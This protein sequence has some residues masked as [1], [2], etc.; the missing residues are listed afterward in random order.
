MN[1]LIRFFLENHKLTIILSIM[2]VAFGVMG[3]ANLNAESFPS[4]NFAMVTVETRY[5]GATAEDIRTKITKPIEDKIREVSGLKDVRSVSKS[6]L[7]SIFVRVDMDNEDEKE[8]LEELQ[9]AVDSVNDLPADLRDDPVYTELN[10]EEFPAVEIAIMGPNDNRERDVMTDLLKEELEDSK[11]V[12]DA[13]LVGWQKRQF[14]IR[15]D[16]KK[17]EAF[18]IGL[19]EVLRKIRQ[20][21]VDVPG[22]EL[23]S[24]GRQKLIRVEG[25]IASAEE[26]ANIVIRSNFTGKNIRLKDIAQVEDDRADAEV[27]ASF[28]GEPAVFL[29]VN[30]KGGADTI[31]LVEEVSS[32]IER[33]KKQYKDKFEIV[34][35]NNEALK[36]RKKLDILS[37]NAL[38]GLGLVIFFLF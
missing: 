32:I 6:G 20:R 26:L 33:F 7:S 15:V 16:Q 22:G 36:V 23:Q 38:T 1:A 10:S 14:N 2:F 30:K 13:R 11:K 27:L 34:V 37:S 3:L 4:V 31:A 28:N 25:K 5:E 9:K 19:E 18:H 21:N 24:E 17:M 12:K 35:Y 8:V 29:V